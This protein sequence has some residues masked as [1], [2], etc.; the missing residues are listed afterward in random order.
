MQTLNNLGFNPTFSLFQRL[1]PS[2]TYLLIRLVNRADPELFPNKFVQ[3]NN[4]EFCLRI[5]ML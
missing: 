2:L 1:K 5:D 4:E 3:V